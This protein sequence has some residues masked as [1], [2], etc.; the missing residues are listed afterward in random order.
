MSTFR[1]L[2]RV[3]RI[4]ILL[5]RHM[6][7]FRFHG[8][9][10]KWNDTSHDYCTVEAQLTCKQPGMQNHPLSPH[11]GGGVKNYHPQMGVG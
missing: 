8:L 4:Q 3:A 6:G 7:L 5:L 2:I 11:P 10:K 9:E 1:H